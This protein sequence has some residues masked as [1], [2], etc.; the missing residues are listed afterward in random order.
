MKSKTI[1]LLLVICLTALLNAQ[2]NWKPKTYTNST[3]LYAQVQLSDG[4]IASTGDSLGAFV[5]EECRGTALIS[6]YNNQAISAIVINGNNVETI[7][8]KLW[9]KTSNTILEIEQTVQSNPGTRITWPP[10][11]PTLLKV[12]QV[13]TYSIAFTKSGTGTGQIKITV[14]SNSPIT[15]SLPYTLPNLAS[16]TSVTF[17]AI[18]DVSSNF[19]GWSGDASGTTNPLTVTMNGNKNIT[20]NFTLN[21]YTL[22]VN[23]TNGTVS[24]NP[25]LARYN[26]GSSV[27]LTATANSGYT[28]TGWSGDASGTTNPLPVIMNGNKSITANFTLESSTLPFTDG[29]ESGN[30]TTGNW[31]ASTNATIVD[32]PIHSGTKAARVSPNHSLT[33]NFVTPISGL[34]EWSF[35]V[36]VPQAN[37]N[38]NI[39]LFSSSG[40]Y[41]VWIGIRNTGSFWA[42][43][44]SGQVQEILPY[45]INT[46]Y[47]IKIV[48]NNT[49]KKYDLYINDTKYVNQ[50]N[51]YGTTIENITQISF[52]G[53]DIGI[54]YYDDI[55]ITNPIGNDLVAYYPFNNN[56][57]DESGNGNNGTNNGATLTTDRFG[58]PNK[59][60]AFNGTSN[61]IQIPNSPTLENITNQLTISG[62]IY[63]NSF[64]NGLA[65]FLTKSN[66]SQQATQYGILIYDRDN[67]WAHQT[68]EGDKYITD[69]LTAGQWHF[70]CTTWDG[71]VVKFYRDGKY[72][73]SQ[74]LTTITTKTQ[75]PLLLGMDTPG[76]TEFLNGKL[77]DIR[78]YS[79]VL[80]D[81][82]ISS[83]YTQNG[84]GIPSKF[85]VN[86]SSTQLATGGK[87]TI[88]AQ[89]AD[90]HGNPLPISGKIVTWSNSGIGGSFSTSTSITNNDGIATVVFTV[91]STP[92]IIHAVTA[93]DNTS[94]TAI[95]GTGANITV[96]NPNDLYWKQTNLFNVSN[97][98]S[99][100]WFGSNSLLA[101]LDGSLSL[102]TDGGNSW[103]YVSPN[104]YASKLA[105]YGSILYCTSA[106]GGGVFKSTDGISWTSINNGIDDLD[107]RAIKVGNNGDIFI[108]SYTGWLYKSTN[109]G[110]NW[111]KLNPSNQF[112][113]WIR[114]IDLDSKGNIFAGVQWG[115][116][117]QIS[118]DGG[119]TW[120]G[121]NTI[122]STL[123]LKVLPNDIIYVGTDGAGVFKSQDSGI[124]W[125]QVNDGLP[126][127]HIRDIIFNSGLV[128]A[129]G[130]GGVSFCKPTDSKWTIQNSGFPL[131]TR[132]ISFVNDNSNNIYVGLGNNNYDGGSVYKTTQPINNPSIELLSPNGGENWTAGSNQT[133]TWTSTN[134]TSNVNIKLSVDGGTTFT[135]FLASNIANDGSEQIR[136]PNNISSICKIK[137]ESIDQIVSGISNPFTITFPTDLKF[138]YEKWDNSKGQ[139]YAAD[140]SFSKIVQLTNEN[141]SS[142]HPK[143]SPDGSK[144]VYVYENGTGGGR[145]EIWIMNQDGSGKTK[146]TN[147]GTD[148]A[149]NPSWSSDGSKIIYEWGYSTT[150]QIIR[151]VNIDGTNDQ[152]VFNNVDDKDTDPVMNP[153]NDRRIAYFYDNGNWTYNRVLKVRDLVS[154]V[155]E[156][157]VPA[158]GN[159]KFNESWSNSGDEILFSEHT[160]SIVSYLKKVKVNSKVVKTLITTPA[161]YQVTG[162]FSFDTQNIYYVINNS[163]ESKFYKADSSGANNTLLCSLTGNV[164][165]M[166]YKW[167]LI[168]YI[169]LTSP[170]GGENWTGGSQQ[171]V[172]WNSSNITENVAIKLS[173]DGGSTY[174]TTLLANT[175]NDGTEQITLP[176]LTA[177]NTTCRIKVE[178]VGDASVFGASSNNFTISE[179]QY[180]YLTKGTKGGSDK[181]VF[182]MKMDGSEL[183][184]IYDDNGICQHVQV[185]NDASKLVFTSNASTSAKNEIFL[186]NSSSSNVLQLTSYNDTYGT[187]D[188]RF[189][190]TT[191][192]WFD[193]SPVAGVQEWWEM[194]LDGTAKVQKSNWQ[195]I[196]KQSQRFDFNNT[197]TKIVYEKGN[198]SWAPSH[199]IFISNID[200]TGEQQLTSN[201]TYSGQPEFSQDG[202]K[203]VFIESLTDN[204]SNVWIMN[205][206][207]SSKTNLTNHSVSNT[208]VY[209]AIFSN[210]GSKII[211]SVFN[212]TQSDIFSMDIDGNNK[213]NLTNTTDYDEI[214][215]SVGGK[216][217]PTPLKTIT[218]TAPNGGENWLS[219]ST[220]TVTW[221]S[222]NVTGNVAI[223]LS[224]DG[225]ST[226]TSTLV[227]NS[228]NDGTEQITLPTLTTTNTT[229]RI[230]VE[231]VSDVSVFG[232][233]AAN[234]TITIIN[235][236]SLPVTIKDQCNQGGDFILGVNSSATNGIDVGLGEGALPPTPPS[237]VFDARFELS[238]GLEF[239]TKDLRPDGQTINWII[240]FQPSSC[241]YP[242]TLSWDP[243]KLPAGSF[244]LKDLVTGTIVNVNMKSQNSYSVTNSAITSLK[245]SFS[246]QVC[247]DIVIKSGWNIIALPIQALDMTKATLFPEASSPAWKYSN[248]YQQETNLIVG[249]GYWVRYPNDKTISICGSNPSTITIPVLK[250]WNL[251]GV[252]DFNVL[253]SSI[254]TEPANITNTS[255]YG[256]DNGYKVPTTLETGKGYWIR[257]TEDGVLKLSN[258]APKLSERNSMLA[259]IT[260]QSKARITIKD[261]LGNQEV[262]YLTEKSLQSEELDLP[263]TPP[264]GIFDVRWTNDSKAN[265]LTNNPQLV[266][267]S[268]VYPIEI[269]VNG[270]DL[271]LL[272]AIGGST[273]NNVVKNGNKITIS[274]P[275]INSI[276]VSAVEIPNKYALE[277]N[278]PNPF[279]PVTNIKYAIPVKGN[280]QLRVFDVLGKVV[281]EIVNEEQEAGSYSVQFDS[282]N[283]SS[284]VY[285]YQI[286]AGNFVETKKLIL[287]K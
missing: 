191:K 26:H 227:A 202:S 220:Q 266:V 40:N 183:E 246:K 263:P 120:L 228:A 32:S 35:W 245:I 219:G 136:I 155:D 96:S 63:I 140:E 257:V 75:K 24:K 250:G 203:I 196:N 145:G 269:T 274:N 85:I 82:E 187:H 224:T 229:C 70:I 141:L 172:N 201:S 13:P 152:L 18:Q 213:L 22:T 124:S 231:S 192:I 107:I 199:D 260:K 76:Q 46:W 134:V 37:S 205:I 42:M 99:L 59:A 122:S 248:G 132:I 16:G 189:F 170:I 19:T 102:S 247:K 100:L 178:S 243:T 138:V 43:N 216:F 105:S 272:D 142:Y 7:K 146:L 20:A 284:G 23:A 212:G 30:F 127:N 97:V 27:Q 89:L 214:V 210:D 91:S 126:S 78:I 265:S 270:T 149:R 112:S 131:D 61:Y 171:T 251:V 211:Y 264:N 17:E 64:H 188:P 236:W 15:Q 11:T 184:S 268:A 56:S 68:Y 256:Y 173:T 135:I 21:T 88:L 8:F 94:P 14:G 2:P 62:W 194:N 221:N 276:L 215:W 10:A 38:F 139:I 255:F 235:G 166:D 180:L 281:T 130:L 41:G 158:N 182:R 240:K 160:T 176:S 157:I 258:S 90:I 57:N 234:F 238:N 36:S 148:G 33:K 150:E 200:L 80:S 54:A 195:S 29:F 77:D 115:A 69:K 193:R 5:G 129:G 168:K 230:K 174:S 241:G 262:L 285:Y 198:P 233:S 279:N 225:G 12:V 207:G 159:T 232:S 181:D 60:Y 25:N 109:G 44:S 261:A 169:A 154:S 119:A 9:R 244:Y 121:V 144:I 49:T 237:G 53:A 167:D 162:K 137:I 218:V 217:I 65:P 190:N 164:G 113:G 206:D 92:G 87:V 143:W 58:N 84:W 34:I 31:T 177:T 67:L 249:K 271:T 239:S 98:N 125:I 4:T 116:G 254:A 280:V 186:L 222:T 253:V 74:P 81:Q 48:A 287:L 208:H 117:V 110:T 147:A 275:A 108:G 185:S 66:D 103:Q 39:Q 79:S 93:I 278:Y 73:G 282:S 114:S 123:C 209:S 28:F 223:K 118:K 252:Y 50:W 6:E 163:T 128:F 72:L 52:N 165:Y 179:I 156:V 259:E 106:L 161:N 86:S 283:L 226:Y 104:F 273:L 51:F 101:T 133:I 204:I 197:F 83:Q 45:T 111:T 242:V 175:A 55:S 153:R 151:S 71:A 47:K 277:Q 267:N 95:S 3:T 1:I 286:R